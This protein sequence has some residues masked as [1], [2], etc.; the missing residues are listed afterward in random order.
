M[1]ARNDGG[2]YAAKKPAREPGKVGEVYDA[3]F[4]GFI[5]LNLSDS[6]KREFP[7]WANVTDMPSKM[8]NAC[9]DGIVLSLKIDQKSGGFMASATQRRVSSKNAGLAV[10]ARA[11]DAGTALTRL[12]YML[13]ILPWDDWEALQPMADPDRW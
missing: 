3:V 7:A 12:L 2:K 9:V 11:S 8:Q 13:D 10:T 4:R 1:G 6:Q 5:N